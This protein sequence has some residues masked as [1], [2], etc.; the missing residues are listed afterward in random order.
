MEN[1]RLN[2]TKRVQILKKLI[3]GTIISIILLPTI[4]CVI[5]FIRINGIKTA[6]RDLEEVNSKNT[7]EI[8]DLKAEIE[9][10]KS[11]N[12][13]ETQRLSSEVERLQ[14][15]LLNAETTQTDQNEAK[16]PTGWPRKV[17]LTFDDGPSGHTQEILDILDSY[18]VKGNFFVCATQ[19]EDYQK[20]YQIILDKGHMLGLHSYTHVYEDIYASEEAFQE[21]VLSIRSFVKEHT[22]GYEAV[23][24]RFPGGST[25]L[26]S[27]I[28]LKAC[29]DWLEKQGLIYYDWNLSSQ[30]ATN[31][32]QSADNIFHNATYGCEQYEEV[33]ILMHDLGNKDSTV[34]ALPRII[35][36]YQDI[37]A[38]IS[39]I[40]DTSMVIRHDQ[41]A[42]NQ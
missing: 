39:I 5:L 18:G 12:L 26:H 25:N 41:S 32:M 16:T 9:E 37:G 14:N 11:E 1:D 34:E 36:Y 4:L 22:D 2:R 10:N 20:Y 21:D 6:L 17:Y 38:K 13:Q 8:L 31:P 3:V 15:D 42:N 19:N 7:S 33:V 30:D 40:D 28:S 29:A 23:Y 24:Y 35:E 27:R